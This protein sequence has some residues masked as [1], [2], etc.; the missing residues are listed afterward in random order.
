MWKP[1]KRSTSH[2]V[3]LF[4]ENGIYIYT[5]LIEQI[6]Y[7]QQLLMMQ[8][9]HSKTLYIDIA[10]VISKY[11]HIIYDEMR[12]IM[13]RNFAHSYHFHIWIKEGL[14][15]LKKAI[16]LRERDCCLRANRLFVIVIVIVVVD[17]V[18]NVFVHSIISSVRIL[19]FMQ[20][21]A[22][23]IVKV[24]FSSCDTL[25]LQTALTDVNGMIWLYLSHLQMFCRILQLIMITFVEHNLSD[26]IV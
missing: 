26:C 18:D 17:V 11:F 3:I 23:L 2:F 9:P 20:I 10:D 6:F 4:S 8:L 21:F 15:C 19:L 13:A 22:Y 24:S 1:L 16:A 25:C 7:T 12:T 14:I 5:L